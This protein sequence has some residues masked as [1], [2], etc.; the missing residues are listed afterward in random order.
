[1]KIFRNMPSWLRNKYV[2]TAI[3]FVLWISFFDDRDLLTNL[4]RSRE[5]NK[6][7]ANRDYYRDQIKNTREEL[8]KL[9]NEPKALEK[10]A[11]EHYRMKKDNEELYITPE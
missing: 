11:R 5:L 7:E 9:R 6:L 3:G 1:M 8:D 2:L 10:Y 4:R